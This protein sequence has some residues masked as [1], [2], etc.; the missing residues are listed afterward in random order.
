[1]K[2]L[3][4][5]LNWL[6]ICLAI[7]FVGCDDDPDDECV[8][9]SGPIVS[10]SRNLSSFH[11]IRLEG[12]GNVLL[13]Q[14][15]I[16]SLRIES[17]AAI[18]SRLQTAVSNEQLTISLQGC[19]DGSIPQLDIFIVIPDIELLTL[20]GVGNISAQNDF[21]EGFIGVDLN[22]VGS[23]SLRGEAETLD[24]LSS[25][26]GSLMAFDMTTETCDVRLT[27][28]GNVE[29]TV[30]NDLAVVISGAGSVRYKGTPNITSNISGVG[31]LINAN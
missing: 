27:G 19:V 24:V 31:S 20:Q 5:L 23:I 8:D 28:V 18:I 25:G 7:S 1:M 26:V 10:E 4:L 30:T 11:S 22:G 16:Q 13:T 6:V 3:L 21:K 2:K 15:P 14:G 29:V 17:T 9:A 12:I